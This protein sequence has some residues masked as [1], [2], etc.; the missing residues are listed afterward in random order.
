M[1]LERKIKVEHTLIILVI[2]ADV[3]T[4]ECGGT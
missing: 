4:I 3:N 1:S 2:L